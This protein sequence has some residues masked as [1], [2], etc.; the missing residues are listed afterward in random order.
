[1]IKFTWREALIPASW[2]SISIFSAIQL[3]I[4]W[5]IYTYNWDWSQF[6]VIYGRLWPVFVM[7]VVG[8]FFFILLLNKFPFLIL[9]IFLLSASFIM[10]YGS[11]L[12]EANIIAFNSKF[13]RYHLGHKLLKLVIH[14]SCYLDCI[15]PMYLIP[16]KQTKNSSDKRCKT[17]SNKCCISNKL[18]KNESLKNID[19]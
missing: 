15:V 4:I 12:N 19:L 5:M 10:I 2:A 9:S 3:A 17:S 16:R 18:A 8:G 7:L 14:F 6:I 1:M 11:M 13:M